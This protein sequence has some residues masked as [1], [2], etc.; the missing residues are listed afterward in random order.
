MNGEAER[1]CQV[2]QR[3]MHN[4]T[5]LLPK[6][7]NFTKHC[8]VKEK[9]NKLVFF[10]TLSVHLNY[11]NVNRIFFQVIYPKSK[12]SAPG[13][14]KVDTLSKNVGKSAWSRGLS[15]GWEAA[16]SSAITRPVPG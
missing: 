15:T 2:E 3:I 8:T 6:Q 13:W 5:K 4:Q 10:R 11:W 16:G 14:L 12:D 7:D 9:L 1:P